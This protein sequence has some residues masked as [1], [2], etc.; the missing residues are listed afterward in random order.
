MLYPCVDGGEGFKRG[1]G[2]EDECHAFDDGD[3]GAGWFVGKERV[4]MSDGVDVNIVGD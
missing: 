1:E 2:D 4:G 3:G